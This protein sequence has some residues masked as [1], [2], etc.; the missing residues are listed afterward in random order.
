MEHGW[1]YGKNG[2][3]LKGKTVFNAFTSGG[4]IQSYQAEGFQRCTIHEL[5]R[6]FERTA[7]LL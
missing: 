4:S 7:Q 1:A 5:L 6:P 2:V 3:A